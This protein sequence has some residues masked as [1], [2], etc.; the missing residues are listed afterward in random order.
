[1]V[2]LM[3]DHTGVM[4]S[5]DIRQMTKGEMQT[6]KQTSKQEG[7]YIYSMHINMTAKMVS[8]TS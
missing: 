3:R 8:L 4:S 5:I 2:I 7:E 1:V 6:N